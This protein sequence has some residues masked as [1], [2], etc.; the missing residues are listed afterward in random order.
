MVIAPAPTVR[1]TQPLT[2]LPRH[3]RCSLAAFQ[4]AQLDASL[5]DLLCPTSLCGAPGQLPC[6]ATLP[7]AAQ[8]DLL[9]LLRAAPHRFTS[10]QRV[11]LLAGID[12]L[13]SSRAPGAAQPSLLDFLAAE[14]RA[15]SSS[16]WA[17]DDLPPAPPVPACPPFLYSAQPCFPWAPVRVDAAAAAALYRQQQAAE[18]AATQQQPQ[19]ATGAK[20]LAEEA[21]RAP[22]GSPGKRTR[23]AAGGAQHPAPAMA[24]ETELESAIGTMRDLLKSS[25]G[26]AGGGATPVALTPAA[27]EALGVLLA[28]A[29]AGSTAALHDAGLTS[30]QDDALLLLLLSEAVAAGSSFARSSAAAAGLLL[31]RLRALGGAASRDLAAAVEHVG[32]WLRPHAWRRALGAACMAQRCSALLA[33]TEIGLTFH[34]ACCHRP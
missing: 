33:A 12:Q 1:S 28:H 4:A 13:T 29:A 7:L 3:C 17:P 11:A 31:P 30:L 2:R 20:R 10:S 24:A 26:C 23:L 15:D 8:A 25:S 5:Q 27:K 34:L 16:S 6:L 21:A 14:V 19:E 18:A 9:L 32:G 22:G